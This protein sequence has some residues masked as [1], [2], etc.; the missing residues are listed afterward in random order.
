MTRTS[1]ILTGLFLLALLPALGGCYHAIVNTGASPGTETISQPWAHSFLFGLV[2]PST[3]DAA[4]ECDSGVARVETQLSFL[5]QIA[6][7]LTGGIYSPMT[8]EV[9][10]ASGGMGDDGELELLETREEVEDALEKGETFLIPV[11]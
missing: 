6:Y 4:D 7:I 11:R 5:N 2:P 10:C 3:V 1:R 9:T 8:I